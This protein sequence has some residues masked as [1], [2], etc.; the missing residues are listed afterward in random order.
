MYILQSKS[1]F[2]SNEAL[3]ENTYKKNEYKMSWVH[4]IVQ[5]RDASNLYDP[6]KEGIYSALKSIIKDIPKN[7]PTK[8]TLNGTKNIGEAKLTNQFGNSGEIR[9]KMK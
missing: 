9:T 7:V 8:N 4:G 1:C 6:Y 2:N 5:R 3:W